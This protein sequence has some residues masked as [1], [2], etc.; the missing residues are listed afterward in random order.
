VKFNV[1]FELSKGSA[2]IAKSAERFLLIIPEASKRTE[3]RCI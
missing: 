2:D 3:V 1:E